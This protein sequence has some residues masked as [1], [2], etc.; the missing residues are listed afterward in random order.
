MYHIEVLPMAEVRDATKVKVDGVV[1]REQFVALV[2]DQQQHTVEVKIMLY[3]NRPSLQRQ[4]PADTTLPLFQSCE[5]G[6]QIQP[7]LLLQYH[8][9][10]LQIIQRNVYRFAM[11]CKRNGFADFA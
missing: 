9:L 7:C 5:S 8:C 3:R 6:Q 11:S 1:R 4:H 2:N 10:L